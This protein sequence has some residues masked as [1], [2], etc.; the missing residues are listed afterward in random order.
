[1]RRSDIHIKVEI[2][3]GSDEPPEKLAAEICRQV[4]KI[5]GV[6]AAEVSNIVTEAD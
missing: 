6:R 2:E 5:Y 3:Y 1:M 4:K